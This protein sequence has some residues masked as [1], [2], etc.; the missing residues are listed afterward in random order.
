MVRQQNGKDLQEM[1]GMVR[2]SASLDMEPKLGFS[3][4]GLGSKK[5]IQI[6][7]GLPTEK[8]KIWKAWRRGWRQR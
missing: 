6:Y 5:L 2:M 7:R 8:C 1:Q 3:Q 4:L